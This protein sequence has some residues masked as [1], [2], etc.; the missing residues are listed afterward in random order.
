M[1]KRK[2]SLVSMVIVVIGLV[3]I[4]NNLDERMMMKNYRDGIYEVIGNYVSPG[5]DE[6]IKV[7]VT[8]KDNVIA[9]ADVTP[10]ATRPMSVKFQEKFVEGYKKKVVG[11]NINKVRLNKVSG[12]SLTPKGFNNAIEKIKVEAEVS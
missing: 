7:K 12:S 11:K 1:D 5:G 6:T 8:L 4:S 2:I 3:L 9:D 10:E